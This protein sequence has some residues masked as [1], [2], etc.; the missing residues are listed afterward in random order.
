MGSVYPPPSSPPPGPSISYGYPPQQAAVPLP[1]RKRRTWVIVL[2]IFAGLALLIV[3]FV[4]GLAVVVFAA[5]RSSEPYQHAI[6]SATHDARAVSLLGAPVQ[7]GWYVTGSENVSGGFGKA[8]LAVPVTGS[9][10]KGR[11]YV[12]ATK[13][14]GHWRYATLELKVDGQQDRLNLLPHLDRQPTER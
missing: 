12:V 4:A 6:Q 14:A 7:A 11:V 1:P 13:S 5:I 2:S 8:D 9:R 10:R 3:L